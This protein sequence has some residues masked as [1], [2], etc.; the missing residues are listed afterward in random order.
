MAAEHEVHANRIH[1]RYHFGS[2]DFGL[3]TSN[4]DTALVISK[5]RSVDSNDN[6]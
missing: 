1:E 4:C 3:E 6:I 2:G 5:I